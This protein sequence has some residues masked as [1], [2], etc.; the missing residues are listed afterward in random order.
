MSLRDKHNNIKTVRAISP[1]Q[2]SDNTAQVGEIIDTQDFD[3]LELIIAYG[4]LADAAATFTPLVEDGED[5][6]LSDAA[7]VVD[8]QLLGTEVVT[9]Q[10]GDDTIVK[11]GYIGFKRFVR[12]T[13]TPADNA[14]AA[15]LS[16]V[17]V[18]GHAHNAPVA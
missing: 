8:S 7:P 11:I 6:G 5:S 13:I 17:A 15:D 12:L 10:D 9:D 16:A 1:V 4:T 14:S 18:L 3:S 2:V